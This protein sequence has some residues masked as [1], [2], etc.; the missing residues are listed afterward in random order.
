MAGWW[1]C[2]VACLRANQFPRPFAL[3]A[4]VDDAAAFMQEG[5]KR[6]REE[7]HGCVYHIS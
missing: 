2:S 6:Y 5:S 7:R 1:G 3:V 4:A